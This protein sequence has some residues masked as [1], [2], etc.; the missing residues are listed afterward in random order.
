MKD[1]TF[2]MG[3]VI[4]I[5]TYLL[6]PSAGWAQQPRPGG[7]LRVAW[8]A[9]ISGLDPHLSFGMQARLVVGNLFNSLVTIDPELNFVPDLAESWEVLDN[10]KV[11]VFHLR[12]GVKFHDGT[13]FD[14]EAVRWNYQRVVDP[15]E[16][17]LDAPYYSGVVADVEA[18]DA[19]TVKFT[20]KHPTRTLLAAL[21]ADR[22][23]FLLM[24]PASY[25]K[26]GREDVR[27]HPVG[28]GPFKLAKWEQNQVIAL[29][30]NPHYFKPG[31]PYLDRVELR[32]MK[33]GVT[34]VTALRAGE[35]DFANLV[36]REHVERLSREPQVYVLRGK[37]TQRIATFFNLR[38]PAFQDVRVRRAVLGYGLD[39][40]AI[41]K[42]ALLGQAQPLWSFVP[43]G[44][45]GHMDLGEQFPHD[46]VRAR[47]LLKEAGY[48]AHNPLRYT[49]M[50]HSAEASLP[51]I[52]TVMK[53]Q[54]AQIGV[55]V[56]L[57]VLDRPIFL[58]RVTRDRDWDQ[59]LANVA[60]AIDPHTISQGIDSRA[61]NNAI[62][63]ADPQVDA[64]I[65]RLRAATTEEAYLQAGYDF[66]RYVV[67]NM[68]STSVSSYAHLQ[69]ARTY[70][71]GYENLHGYKL[72]FE[73][74]WLDN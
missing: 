4:A 66:Q 73:T 9:D 26:W 32:I 28:T 53:T 12:K 43:P 46:P 37:D 68:M 52:A 31:L 16:K 15:E 27:L 13:D 35:V 10:S 50:T 21:A 34:R 72:R 8:E 23:G 7:T 51:I 19:H 58:R 33:D 3:L 54:L 6:L 67:E 55:E 24:S 25:K 38:K 74:T 69:A 49:L 11:Y 45:R 71:K 48:D 56:E 44:S 47:A 20:L 18:L 30:K 57:E 1:H 70:V 65:D 59:F 63:H 5:L 60:A 64:L 2:S 40:P 39:R 14:A 42:T 36:P 61:G 41:V 17:T 22:V 62:N 29:E